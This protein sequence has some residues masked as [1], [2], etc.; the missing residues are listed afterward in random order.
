MQ[1]Y[2]NNSPLTSVINVASACARYAH[3]FILYTIDSIDTT[4]YS[5]YLKRIKTTAHLQGVVPI[6]YN[7]R[8]M[9]T[10][11]IDGIESDNCT[12]SRNDILCSCVWSTIV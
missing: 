5:R 7:V 2:F 11:E 4:F 1:S 10:I 3:E 9:R 8:I 12:Q 6:M